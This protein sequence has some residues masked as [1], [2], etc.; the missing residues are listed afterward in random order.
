M[1]A[2]ETDNQVVTRF[3]PSPTG[4]LHI[5]GAR[6]ALF[7]YLFAR[8]HGGK[9]LVRIEDT[10]K[11]RSTP[12]AIAAIHDGLDWLGLLGDEEPVFQSQRAERHAEVAQALLDK[13]AAYKCYLTSDELTARREAAQAA[14]KPFR[15]NSEWR[16]CEPGPEQEGQ[17][18]VVRL[19]APN[20]GETVIEDMVQGRISVKNEE[21]DDFI[22]L[23]SDGTPTYMLAVVVDDHD[24]GVTHIL[25]GDDHLNNAFR[26][27]PLIKAMG[28]REP[29]YGHVPL[30]HGSDGAKLSKRHGA[31]GV[32]A[33]REEMGLLPEAV[34]NYLLRLGWGHGDEEIIDRER[35]IEL[36]DA[37]GIGKSPSRFDTKKLLNLNGH[38]IREADNARLAD[39]VAE[40]AGAT[41]EGDKA[42]LTRAM[43]ELKARARD[44]HE[45]AAG[46]TFLF[47]QR[48]LAM[49]DKAEQLLDDEA[50][51]NLALAHAALADLPRWEMET[52]ETA[53]REVAEKAELKL[54][55]LAQP[56]RAALTGSNTSP[57]IFDVL[58]LLGREESLARIADQMRNAE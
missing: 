24:M 12:E 41:S 20:E 58:V 8:H 28:W 26:Q 46:A 7:N 11:K 35:A 40:E 33:Y 25:R 31:L 54:G 34:F 49:T 1:C 17:P 6:T 51:E 39:L 48:P 52:V 13:G 27:L 50:R 18:F 55:K 43:P 9:Y 5:G 36:F 30:I 23:R 4:F 29:T 21:I 2:S 44:L 19:K 3:A 22:L 14:K 42:L 57:G 37:S 47:K 53:V 16:D 15:L 10:D 32:D 45:L 56:L 38:Y